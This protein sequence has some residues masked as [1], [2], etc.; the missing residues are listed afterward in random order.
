LDGTSLKPRKLP[1]CTLPQAQV[2]TRLPRSGAVL[3]DNFFTVL[4][5]FATTTDI[6]KYV[7]VTESFRAVPDLS[8]W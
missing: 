2:K 4:F 1:A 8:F 5:H 6:C 7:K 3:G